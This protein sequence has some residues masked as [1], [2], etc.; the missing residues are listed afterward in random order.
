MRAVIT[1]KLLRSLLAKGGRRK[2]IRDQALIGFEARPRG[3]WVTFSAVRRLPGKRQPV[4]VSVG[5]FPEMTLTQ[6]R[7]RARL[8]LCDLSDG[9]DPRARKAE[10]LQ[11]RAAENERRFDAVAE[12]F[13]RRMGAARTHR[14]IEQRIRRELISRWGGRS[15]ETLTRADIATLVTSIADRGHP[16]AARQT[17]IYTKRLFAWALTRGLLGTHQRAS[18]GR[19]I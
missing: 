14:D 13:I 16:E 8:L 10:Q 12:Q 19:R 5:R 1:E 15:I 2:P 17:L 7:D 6:A 4:R 11:Q 3:R 9:V 18:S